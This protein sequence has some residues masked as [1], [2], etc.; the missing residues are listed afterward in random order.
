MAAAKEGSQRSL[1]TGSALP[2]CGVWMSFSWPGIIS[3]RCCGDRDAWAAAAMPRYVRNGPFGDGTDLPLRLLRLI[4]AG[5]LADELDV[6]LGK[7]DVVGI[8]RAVASAHPLV[9]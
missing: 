8:G 1:E 7:D 4:V 3:D 6:A 2:E 9:T 5:R